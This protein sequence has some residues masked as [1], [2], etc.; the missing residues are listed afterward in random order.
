M[1][2]PVEQ[3]QQM[4]EISG[5]S[6]EEQQNFIARYE[7]AGEWTPELAEEYTEIMLTALS[8]HD[9]QLALLSSDTEKMNR[10]CATLQKSYDD[11]REEA[12]EL[13]TEQSF[14]IIDK[15]QQELRF[16]TQNYAQQKL[17]IESDEIGSVLK[18]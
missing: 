14:P 15:A 9:E 17:N 12:F 1:H 4:L 7:E 10:E 16:I 3:I 5:L 13:A 2:T 8:I 18:V 11:A 6:D